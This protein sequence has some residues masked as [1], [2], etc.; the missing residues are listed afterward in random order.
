M[1]ERDKEIE[2]GKQRLAWCEK[3]LAELRA[4]EKTLPR[5]GYG[6]AEWKKVVKEIEQLREYIFGEREWIK[7]ATEVETLLDAQEKEWE[8]KYGPAYKLTPE[9]EADFE[10]FMGE[11]KRRQAEREKM[12]REAQRRRDD[13]KLISG[14]K[15]DE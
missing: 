6:R 3:R 5:V 10:L 11:M 4:L 2:K 7:Y 12:N 13:F 15:G 14:G 9:E 1:R 8:A